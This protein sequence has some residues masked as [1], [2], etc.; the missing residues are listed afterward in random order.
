MHSLQLSFI[1][2]LLQNGSRLNRLL[3][4]FSNATR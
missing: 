3:T 2:T 4:D 1:V